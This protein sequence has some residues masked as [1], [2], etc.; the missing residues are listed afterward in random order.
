MNKVFGF[1][2]KGAAPPTAGPKSDTSTHDWRQLAFEVGPVSEQLR[3]LALH[4]NF[5]WLCLTYWLTE[6]TFNIMDSKAILS[7]DRYVDYMM[8]LTGVLVWDPYPFGLPDIF[9]VTHMGLR[10]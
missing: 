6:A 1:R 3:R 2:A 8:G 9:T 10:C 5:R 4:F 7:V